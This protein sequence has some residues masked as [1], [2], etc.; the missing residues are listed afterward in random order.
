MT[1]RKH[2]SSLFSLLNWNIKANANVVTFVAFCFVIGDVWSRCPFCL[3]L[4]CPFPIKP[5]SFA[6]YKQYDVQ[7][8]V[9]CPQNT[10]YGLLSVGKQCN[11]V[12]FILYIDGF[13]NVYFGFGGDR[14]TWHVPTIKMCVTL[15]AP[16]SGWREW[17]GFGTAIRSATD[18]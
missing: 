14:D 17:N 12:D 9:A 3:H 16:S 10:N 4:S 5:N 13:A 18:E 7:N 2:L 15:K 1:A 6:R 11:P 8:V